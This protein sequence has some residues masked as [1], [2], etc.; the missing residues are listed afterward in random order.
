MD[1]FSAILTNIQYVFIIEDFLFS[2]TGDFFWVQ[3]VLPGIDAMTRPGLANQEHHE[4][5]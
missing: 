4:D 3:Y 1:L 5:S 2:G